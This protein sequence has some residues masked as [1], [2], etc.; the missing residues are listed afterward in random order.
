[1]EKRYEY[2][3]FENGKAVKKFTEWFFWGS[4]LLEPIQQKGYKGN[5]LKNEYR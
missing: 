2:W 3:A 5:H 4:D 1:M